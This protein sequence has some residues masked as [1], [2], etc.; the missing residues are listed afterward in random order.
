MLSAA[1]H[2]RL[3]CLD[4]LPL[5]SALSQGILDMFGVAADESSS[6]SQPRFWPSDASDWAFHAFSPLQAIQRPADCVCR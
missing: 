6:C 5:P 4:H 2:L 1:R 3:G